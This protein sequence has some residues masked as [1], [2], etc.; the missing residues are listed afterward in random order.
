MEDEKDGR[1]D[2]DSCAAAR[3]EGRGRV[4]FPNGA[5]LFAQETGRGYEKQKKSSPCVHLSFIG[6]NLDH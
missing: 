2:R 1:M 3:R 4:F 5:V 6:I